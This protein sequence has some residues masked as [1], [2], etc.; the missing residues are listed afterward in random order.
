[1]ICVLAASV[2]WGTTGTAAT[3]A[4]TVGPLAIGAAAMGLGGLLQALTASRRIARERMAL[5]R[6]RSV[7]LVG[8]VAVAI[9]PLAFYTSMHL[10][11]VAAGTVVS[12]G[13]APPA[14]AI[15]ERVIDR[16]NLSRRWIV[17][18]AIGLAG[19]VAL[20]MA[21]STGPGAYQR[22]GPT[23]S[24]FAGM[25]LGLIAGATYAFYSWAA[26]RLMRDGVSPRASMGGIFGLG[27]ILLLPILL[28][29]GA[30]LTASWTNTAVAAYMALVPM[31]TGY[32]LFSVG[33]VR[34]MAST[35][36]TLTLLEP[37]IAAVLAVVVVGE[38]LSA[39]GWAGVA[40]VFGCLVVL[41]V[42]AMET[43]PLLKATGWKP[44]PQYAVAT[45]N[46]LST[47]SLGC[48][49][50]DLALPNPAVEN[51]ATIRELLDSTYYCRSSRSS[52]IM[53]LA[54]LPDE[55]FPL[56]QMENLATRETLTSFDCCMIVEFGCYDGRS[57]EVARFSG[58]RYLG[59]DIDS[60]AIMRLRERILRER[61]DGLAG[62][63]VGNAL[64][65]HTWGGSVVCGKPL[66]VLP[67]NFLGNFR[68]PQQLLTSLS[69]VG[70]FIVL[71]VFNSSTLANTIRRD[72]Y[73]ACGVRDLSCVTDDD[74]SVLFTGADGFYSRS[75]EYHPLRSLMA[76][77]GA[78]VLSATRNSVGQCVTARLNCSDL[79]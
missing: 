29:T 71:S 28:A 56:L 46:A 73:T 12:I 5:R 70:G 37:A 51:E 32:T 26:H 16:C 2:L 50:G 18:A 74:G 41:T 45:L 25:G 79:T 11:G 49:D 61:L 4:P 20:S 23:Q 55:V 6:H 66:H 64:D 43:K 9:Y 40:L 48:R 67:F 65:P 44:V 36:T 21:G 35:A 54:N 42:P 68:N 10:L 78:T 52:A 7:L 76:D 33:L 77:A 19:I 15:I 57:L 1:M 31:F 3:F 8:A 24:T 34:I 75:F 47:K 27:G 13:S 22:I 14:S 62:A 72:Y 30:S 60:R 63:I 38:H 59:V 39:L 69:T 53:R 58:T 17:G